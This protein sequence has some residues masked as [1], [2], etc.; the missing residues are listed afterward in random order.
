VPHGTY[1]TGT[2]YLKSHTELHLQ[3]GA[4]LLG[5]PDR[6]A[7]NADD[8]FPENQAFARERVTGAHLLIAYRCENVS[9]SG[10]GTIDGHSSA[11]FDAPPGGGE[12]PSYRF[13]TGNWP[14]KGWRPARWSSSFAAGAFPL[15]VSRC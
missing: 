2:V 15:P 14:L 13:K 12:R 7:Y 6:A 10:P 5:S 9:I 4:R 8:V 11:F 3:A 1:L